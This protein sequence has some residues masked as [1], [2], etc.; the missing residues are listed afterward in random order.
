M[1]RAE[2]SSVHEEIWLLLPWLANGRLSG[3]ERVQAEAHIR[4][5]SACADELSV[6]QRVCEALSAPER[7]TYAPGPS[8]RKLLD[9]IDGPPGKTGS[10]P[11]EPARIESLVTRRRKSGS[12]AALWRPP[13][14][15][16]AASFIGMVAITGLVA[17]AYLWLQPRFV[18]VTDPAGRQTVLHIAVDRSL[19]IGEVTEL[20]RADGARVVQGPDATGILGVVPAGPRATGSGQPLFD[21]HARL[22]ADPRVRWVQPVDS[23][24]AT[25]DTS[26]TRER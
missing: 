22:A 18:T 24:D 21:L 23:D 2:R 5:C 14:L 20:L 26:T 9:R 10:S 7:V 16:W 11:G 3:A 13:G 12:H 8:F 25:P 15:A 17:T 19:T 4:E 6:Q 1:S